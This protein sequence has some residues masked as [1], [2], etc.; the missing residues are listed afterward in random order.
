MFVITVAAQ[1]LIC[2]H[3]KTYPINAAAIVR[4]KIITPIFQTSLYRYDA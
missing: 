3:T 2:P 1:N 4:K